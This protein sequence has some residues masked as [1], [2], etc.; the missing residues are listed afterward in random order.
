MFR[1]I[2]LDGADFFVDLCHSDV[3]PMPFHTVKKFQSSFFWLCDKFLSGL[4]GVGNS[5]RMML[6]PSEKGGLYR[7]N[8]FKWPPD[9]AVRHHFPTV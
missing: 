9:G 2:P 1:K 8:F 6:V 7:C 4:G 3:I 5:F